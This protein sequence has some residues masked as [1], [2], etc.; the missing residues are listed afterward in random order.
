MEGSN[1]GLLLSNCPTAGLVQSAGQQR[2]NSKSR[3][4]HKNTSHVIAV[5]R[6]VWGGCKNGGIKLYKQRFAKARSEG[7]DVTK[8]LF[9]KILTEEEDHHDTFTTLG[10]RAP[11]SNLINAKGPCPEIGAWPLFLES[12]PSTSG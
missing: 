1:P 6:V 4:D 10:R 12:E 3:S 8:L 2:V 7:D 11:S 5:G 9:E